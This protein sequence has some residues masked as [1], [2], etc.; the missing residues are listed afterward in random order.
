MR[1]LTWG[2][3]WLSWPSPAASSLPAC[4]PH[5]AR[6]W[7]AGC[8]IAE[9]RARPQ[10][11]WRGQMPTPA[12]AS[13]CTCQTGGL[14]TLGPYWF[15][16]VASPWG[17]QAQLQCNTD[18]SLLGHHSSQ[19]HMTQQHLVSTMPLSIHALGACPAPGPTLLAGRSEMSATA[20]QLGTSVSRGPP[21]T[22]ACASISGSAAAAL[23]VRPSC[24]AADSCARMP[25]CCQS[26][27]QKRLAQWTQR[28]YT[29]RMRCA[30]RGSRTSW[31][32]T[33]VAMKST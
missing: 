25:V 12:P 2:S 33:A 31:R 9:A 7:T 11:R 23:W 13:R 26:V 10:A 6:G 24:D 15:P 19:Y 18:A 16:G 29:R 3:V 27:Q 17:R 8:G 4:L 5:P 32:L 22:L 14:G 20:L 21:V 30:E 28:L 1:R